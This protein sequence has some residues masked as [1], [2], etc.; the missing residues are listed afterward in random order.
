MTKNPDLSPEQRVGEKLKPTSP[1][2]RLATRF[3]GVIIRGM[4]DDPMRS[5]ETVRDDFARRFDELA[6]TYGDILTMKRE[7]KRI[8][9]I[10]RGIQSPQP[11]A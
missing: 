4:G 10:I 9:T 5:F 3:T 11:T 6:D 1:E 2:Q 7:N 8:A